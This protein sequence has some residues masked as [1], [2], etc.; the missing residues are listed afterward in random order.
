MN[1]LSM[2][3]LIGAY[4][5]EGYEW[6]EELKTVLNENVNYAYDFITENFKG[7]S[8]A[9]PEGTY[10]LY[11][12][13]EEYCKAN[14]ITLDELIKKGWEYGV[15]WQDGRPFRM[16]YTIRMNLALPKS[17]VEEAFRRLKEYVVR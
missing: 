15:Y 14:N 3:A 16:D 1:V 5:P 8:L 11:I 6:L 17:R 10:M 12:N 7:F 9:K 2:Y 13:C 4:E